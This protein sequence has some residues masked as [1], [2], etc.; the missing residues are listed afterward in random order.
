MKRAGK[1]RTCRCTLYPRKQV[2]WDWTREARTTMKRAGK[3]TICRCASYATK[4]FRWD[5]TGQ[6]CTFLERAT[7]IPCR[8]KLWL[9]AIGQG[10]EYLSQRTINSR[11]VQ[12]FIKTYRHISVIPWC[13]ATQFDFMGACIIIIMRYGLFAGPIFINLFNI[14]ITPIDIEFSRRTDCKFKVRCV[15]CR[16]RGKYILNRTT[17]Y[18]RYFRIVIQVRIATKHVA[19]LIKCRIWPV[20]IQFQT[21]YHWHIACQIHAVIECLI[22]HAVRQFTCN[23]VKQFGWD[24]TT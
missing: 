4:Q 12:V 16:C 10:A 14:S 9:C 17:P 15:V 5:F 24:F 19:N 13:L 8:T 23:T 18:H 2:S 22:E 6:V 21:V 1:H 7:P 11:K 3:H 20:F